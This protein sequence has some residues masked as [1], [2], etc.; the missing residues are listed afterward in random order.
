MRLA[1]EVIRRSAAPLQIEVG[2]KKTDACGHSLIPTGKGNRI[3]S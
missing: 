2:F 1:V 3:L